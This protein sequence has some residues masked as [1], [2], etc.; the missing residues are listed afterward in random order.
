MAEQIQ[1]ILYKSKCKA[2]LNDLKPNDNYYVPPALT[3]NNSTI[4]TEC[5]YWLHM[6]LGVNSDYYLKPH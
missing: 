3:A 2:A 4:S 1:L 6:I 5:I